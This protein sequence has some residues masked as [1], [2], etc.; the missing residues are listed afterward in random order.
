MLSVSQEE[1]LERE[2][3]EQTARDEEIARRLQEKEEVGRL[4]RCQC[5]KGDIFDGDNLLK[6]H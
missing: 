1:K 6:I 3:R 5:A 2:R 4:W